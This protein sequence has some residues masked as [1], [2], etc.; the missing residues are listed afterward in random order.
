MKKFISIICLL[1]MIFSLFSGL[2]A[3]AEVKKG[4]VDVY[5]MTTEPGSTATKTWYGAAIQKVTAETYENTD[6]ITLEDV[7]VTALAWYQENPYWSFGGLHSVEQTE[8]GWE[9]S[10][11]ETDLTG[12]AGVTTS[13]RVE[14]GTICLTRT[15]K[16]NSQ[17]IFQSFLRFFSTFF[18]TIKKGAISRA[19]K[20]FSLLL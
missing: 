9:I 19:Q 10:Y 15:G 13:F 4:D 6:E 16:L 20:V 14:P 17:M 18:P 8:N 3:F 2:S 5:G 7:L 11:E 1:T 12:L